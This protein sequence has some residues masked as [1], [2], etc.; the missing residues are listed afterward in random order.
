MLFDTFS[1]HFRECFFFKFCI[2]YK[3]R[4]KH[5]NCIRLTLKA[6]ILHG[7]KKIV[8]MDKEMGSFR[9]IVFKIFVI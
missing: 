7:N 4:R 3:S 2:L 8:S 5:N 9:G 1:F 6:D